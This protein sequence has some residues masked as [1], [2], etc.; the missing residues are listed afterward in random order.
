[1]HSL[2]FDLK[3]AYQSSTNALN[4]LFAGVQEGLTQARYRVLYAI[5]KKMLMRQSDLRRALGVTAATISKMVRRL[6]ELGVV[7]RWTDRDRR[8]YQL[9]LTHA[10]R[11]WLRRARE[12]LEA[13]IALSVMDAVWPNPIYGPVEKEEEEPVQMAMVGLEEALHL[14]RFAY[15]DR[16][17]LHLHPGW[18]PDD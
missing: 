6:M 15:G 11:D 16:A 13:K 9:R 14:V 10:G 1:M 3:R 17:T 2:L 8:Q 7:A 18:H 4:P 12:Q 5:D